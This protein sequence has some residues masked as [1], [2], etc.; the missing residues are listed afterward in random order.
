M[1]S[2]LAVTCRTWLSPPPAVI[3][4]RLTVRVSASSLSVRFPS[5][6][7]VGASLTDATVTL[8]VVSTNE[9]SSGVP[10]SPSSPPS[11][12]RTVTLAT[13]DL[14]SAESKFR[15]PVRL[16]FENVVVIESNSDGLSL[17]VVT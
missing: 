2:L 5:E 4:E 11:S 3:P 15:L 9:L 1:L 12:T 16:E 13:P 8:N 10:S 17:L 7:I 14:S 6:L